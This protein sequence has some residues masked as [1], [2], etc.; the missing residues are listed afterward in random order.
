MRERELFRY[1]PG[2]DRLRALDPR[3]K[4]PLFLLSAFCAGT[5]K[6]PFLLLML[7]PVLLAAV[8]AQVS[9]AALARESRHLLV[10]AFLLFLSLTFLS[11]AVDGP[12]PLKGAE[13]SGRFVLI[14]FLAHILVKTT[15]TERLGS[16]VYHYLR[17][18][19]PGLAEKSAMAITLTIRFIPLLFDVMDDTADAGRARASASCRNPLRRVSAAVLPVLSVLLERS[20]ETADAL[21]TRGAGRDG[22]MKPPLLGTIPKRDSALFFGLLLYL[23]PVMLLPVLL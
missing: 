2:D 7:P 22:R 8:T 14:I 21:E 17:P 16:A 11:G 5:L 19:S 12:A 18:F 15:S 4:L 20:A 9:P 10:I 3:L 23:V 13:G 1:L 6:G